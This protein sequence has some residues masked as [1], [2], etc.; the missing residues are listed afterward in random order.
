MPNDC[1]SS[2]Y[3]CILFT[4]LIVDIAKDVQHPFLRKLRYKLFSIQLDEA[5]NSNKD[6]HLIACVR[7]CGG[8]SAVEDLL[9]RKTIVLKATAVALLPIL[10]YF[11]NEAKTEWKIC[12][13]M[14]TNVARTMSGRLQCIQALGN[15]NL[16][17]V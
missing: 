12:V 8:M 3:Q 14:C 11:I 13:G 2:L 17:S 1:S 16:H 5:V 9:F 7:F 15:K 6:V 4:H 10:N